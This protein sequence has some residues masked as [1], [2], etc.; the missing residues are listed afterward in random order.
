MASA[1]GG[2]LLK[3]VAGSLNYIFENNRKNKQEEHERFLAE[4]KQNVIAYQK[5][6]TFNDKSMHSGVLWT[7]RL[8]AFIVVGT[9]CYIALLWAKNPDVIITTFIPKEPGTISILWGF[10]TFPITKD[11]T[12]EVSTGA[13]AWGLMNFVS[14]VMALYFT[15]TGKR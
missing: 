8:L 1:A 3:I 14:F 5:S 4:R 11:V 6:L 9:F 12:V 7:R 15:P 10:L 13:I 2:S